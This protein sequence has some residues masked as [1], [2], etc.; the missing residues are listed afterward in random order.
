[1]ENSSK[2]K[3][4]CIFTKDSIKEYYSSLCCFQRSTRIIFLIIC[5]INIINIINN[6]FYIWQADLLILFVI[7]LNYFINQRKTINGLLGKSANI[8]NELHIT[9]VDNR[10]IINNDF[11][12]KEETFK[13]D[14][15][16][17]VIET[18]NLLILQLINKRYLPILK[19]S[20]KDYAV[21]EFTNYL[22]TNS[23]KLRNK[24]IK[25]STFYE[26]YCFILL[27]VL[28]ICILSSF[29]INVLI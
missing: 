15:I 7:G 25:S 5:I 29:I 11:L 12:K 6:N 27:L 22:Y 23:F 21:D 20:L 18:R 14:E 4:K 28:L 19:T 24:K 16:L 17:D 3:C 10:I 2:I 1:M 26:I 13:L 9:I 8:K